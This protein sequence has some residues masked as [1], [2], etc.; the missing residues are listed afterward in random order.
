MVATT[1]ALRLADALIALCL[2]QELQSER[3]RCEAYQ[4]QLREQGKSLLEYRNRAETL[5]A[6]NQVLKD[7]L[8]RKTLAIDQL[9]NEA[10]RINAENAEWRNANEIL[11]AE[12]QLAEQATAAAQLALNNIE[13]V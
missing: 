8:E 2:L 3:E 10:T 12:K 11:K 4:S 7:S 5:S 6:D 1:A 13:Q 9:S